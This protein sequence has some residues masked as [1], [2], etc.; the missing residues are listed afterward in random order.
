MAFYSVKFTFIFR[1]TQMPRCPENVFEVGLIVYVD[2]HNLDAIMHLIFFC[3][4]I[5]NCYEVLAYYKI[6]VTQFLNNVP[7]HYIALGNSTCIFCDG[8]E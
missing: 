8:E 6:L 3:G 1:A 4:Y 7:R 5:R 2:L